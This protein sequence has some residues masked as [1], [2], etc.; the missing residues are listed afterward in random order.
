V[1]FNH[2]KKRKKEM[3]WQESSG[4]SPGPVS[5]TS[6]GPEAASAAGEL[7]DR[8]VAAIDSLPRRY[9]AAFTL[10]AFQGLSHRQAARVLGCS[11]NTV[12]WRM[13]RARQMLR[14][15]LSSFLKEAGHE[16]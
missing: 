13:H 12:S 4:R 11:E 14:E 9:H 1:S 15:E 2:L 16:M 3:A 5:G 7:R 10:V 8:L 6:D